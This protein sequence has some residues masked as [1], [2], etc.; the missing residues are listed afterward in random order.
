M[1]LPV[2]PDDDSTILTRK[3]VSEQIDYANT[4]DGSVNISNS[5]T[6]IGDYAFFNQPSIGTIT[7]PDSVTT[8]G[9]GAFQDCSGLTQILLTDATNLI[10]IG[11]NAFQGCSKLDYIE[12]ATSNITSINGGT[13][14]DCSA[15]TSNVN[16]NTKQII[17]PASVTSIG[18][19]AFNGCSDV[20]SI[21]IHNLVTSIG[22][23][24]FNRCSSLSS[25]TIPES[26]E[27][28]DAGAFAGCNNLTTINI[29]NL[30]TSINSFT[31]NGCSSLTSITIPDSVTS[32]G[33]ESF[34]NCS[35]LTS[36]TI[37][38][39]VTGI[40]YATFRNCSSFTSITIPN[41]VTSI[42]SLAFKGCSS[43]TSIN[44]P[45]SVTSIG[46]TEVFPENLQLINITHVSSSINNTIQD[47]SI[48]NVKYTISFS[49][50]HDDRNINDI[51]D[52]IKDSIVSITIPESVTSI[53]ADAF[54][55]CSRL[56]SIIIPESVTSIGSNAF[57]NC[58]SLKM[59]TMYKGE[60]TY[61][62]EY[63]SSNNTS[64]TNDTQNFLNHDSYP[65]SSWYFYKRTRFT[66]GP[67]K[68]PIIGDAIAE[69][70]VFHKYR[71]EST[72]S[73]LSDYFY[74]DG[75][76]NN[77]TEQD[78]NDNYKFIFYKTDCSGLK[79]DSTSTSGIKNAYLDN[80]ETFLD[81]AMISYRIHNNTSGEESFGLNGAN[82]INVLLV[83][84]GGGG[85]GF[86]SNSQN[87]KH[88]S[89][90]G[91]SGGVVFVEGL[92]VSN[93]ISYNI[94]IGTGGQRG[95]SHDID[96]ATNG[97]TTI[98][99]I[100]AGNIDVSGGYHGGRSGN[101]T[102]GQGGKG[103]TN[104]S[105]ISPTFYGQDGQSNG[106]TSLRGDNNQHGGHGG[107]TPINPQTISNSNVVNTT[108]TFPNLPSLKYTIGSNAEA[109]TTTG[110]VVNT[111]GLV[112]TNNNS[113]LSTSGVGVGGSGGGGINAASGGGGQ[114]AH[115]SDGN[116]G[117]G[118]VFFRYD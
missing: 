27:I 117:I 94:Q 112:T 78:S 71:Y 58:S 90:G 43:L 60:Y 1:S 68:I 37:P 21:T 41:S 56:I 42:S 83:G 101:N 9:I 114:D 65:D 36:I 25:I 97:N 102:K 31:F 14:R 64:I 88:G 74:L 82:K 62:H 47:I 85:G 2:S 20:S 5:V 40:G 59:V 23:R 89:Q 63:D 45:N 55:D 92:D 6:S 84:G 19:N 46:N 11:E 48:D 103:S 109:D 8:I 34:Q 50:N 52:E 91:G 70:C 35:S 12:F 72:H 54:Q 4:F 105:S 28:I 44:I 100:I 22:E 99:Q 86:T 53:N 79:Y 7:I 33:Q 95:T 29:P 3:N 116:D 104:I 93:E 13:F 81:G 110:V 17:I 24:A 66:Y 96:D 111:N 57:K 51:P 108:F 118:I 10:S 98:F 115:G 30:V 106:A 77:L 18:D 113:A 87:D 16:N 75:S 76:T 61:Y 26:V 73:S 107:V 49:D 67:T 15:L 38:N 69:P 80:S 39:S 32:I